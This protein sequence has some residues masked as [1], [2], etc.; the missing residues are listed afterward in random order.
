M[1]ILAASGGY[2]YLIMNVIT[3]LSYITVLYGVQ[4]VKSTYQ[5][6]PCKKYLLVIS[7]LLL[8]THP[9]WTISAFKGDAGTIKL[10]S[11][12]FITYLFYVIQRII[13]KIEIEKS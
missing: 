12:V 11:T 13:N 8:L 6:L 3:V 1:N 4:T 2:T 10:L 9:A 5:L 7:T